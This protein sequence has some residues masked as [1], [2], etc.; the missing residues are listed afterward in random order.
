MTGDV[1][2]DTRSNE[3]GTMSDWVAAFAEVWKSPRENI[4]RLL[5]LLDENVV[6]KAPTTPPVSNG[7]VESR[8]AF[9]RTFR[10]MPDL[11]AE[12][13]RWSAEEDVL[14]IEMSFT[15]T[16]GGRVVTW[17]NVDRFLFRN[18]VAVERIA[19]F[20]PSKLRRAF[21][22]NPRGWTQLV[23]LRIGA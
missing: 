20:N 11:R 12:V 2:L 16:I 13:H 1:V 23:R 15:A 6:L 3:R 4:D 7:T 9:E 14:F 17:R 22:A 19:F 10:A 8:R 18:G 21:L 5:E